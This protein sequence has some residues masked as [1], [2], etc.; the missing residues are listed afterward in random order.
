MEVNKEVHLDEKGRERVWMIDI[1]ISLIYDT[2][3]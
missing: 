2:A 1:F 3:T